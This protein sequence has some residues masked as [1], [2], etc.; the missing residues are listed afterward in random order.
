LFEKDKKTESIVMFGEIGGTY[1][2]KAAETIKDL[3]VTKPIVAFIS[4]LFAETLP[5]G[6]ALGHAGAIIEKGKARR[7]DKVEALEKVGVKIA[8]VPDQIP[9]FLK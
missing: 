2:E 8:Q 3:P 6:L 7:S 9:D 4:G 1:E 5:Q